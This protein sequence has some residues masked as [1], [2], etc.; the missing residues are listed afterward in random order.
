MG[1]QHLSRPSSELR[2]A[3]GDSRP[4][5]PAQPTR[6]QNHLL[7]ALPRQELQRLVPDL[8]PCP[9]PLGWTI[10]DAGD[11]ERYLYFV[12]AGIVSRFYMTASGASAE[13]AVTGNQGVIG[14]AAFLWGRKHEQPSRGAELRP[15]LSAAGRPAAT[16]VRARRP[17]AA[18]AAPL[19]SSA[20]RANR[21]GLGV[22]PAPYAGTA[23]VPLDIVL[24]GPVAH[25]RDGAD[26][27]TDR[28]RAGYASR[29][30]D[31][32]C[33]KAAEG[34][35]YSLRPWPHCRSR[36]PRVGSARVRMLRG[37][38]MR[39]RRFT[40]RLP[41]S[42]SPFLGS[43]RHEGSR[44]P[45]IKRS[46]SVTVRHRE[47]RRTDRIGWLRAPASGVDASIVS[48]ASR[49]LGTNRRPHARRRQC[50]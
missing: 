45:A 4:F 22:Q 29:R 15:Q 24:P 9:L 35:T 31:G 40:R 16:R 7:A 6:R 38:Q 3:V 30:R 47:W 41:A 19:H 44:V 49:V 42:R 21:A 46:S 39:V 32:G 36:P 37:C 26:I 13:F 5:V 14:I 12:T 43:P 2:L 34:G 25:Q 17:A 23:F 20:H 50:N 1:G 27:G 18:S 8:E 33:R 48:T 11:R 28:R 10:H